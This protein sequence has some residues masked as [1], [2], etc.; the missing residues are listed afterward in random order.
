MKTKVSK[1]YH[2][3]VSVRDYVVQKA[4]D[5]GEPLVIEHKSERMTVPVEKLGQGIK[6]F[7]HLTSKVDGK[8][9]DLID[10]EW[11]PDLISNN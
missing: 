9:Y 6:Q 5:K 2:G 4:I 8:E 7:L 10:Y 1:I 11:K 3:N